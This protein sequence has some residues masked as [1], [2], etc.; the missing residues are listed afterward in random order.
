[1]DRQAAV[2]PQVGDARARARAERIALRRRQIFRAAAR[3][4]V[5]TGYHGMSM[6]AVAD[7]AKMS[8]GLIYQYVSSK[9]ELLQSTI[10]DILEEFRQ[11]VPAAMAK[12]GDDPQ[13]RLVEGFRT[14]CTIIDGMREATLLAYRE[15]Q[16]LPKSGASEVMRL[17]SETMAPL[18]DAVADGIAN[19][20]FRPVSA[21][22]VAHN[23]KMI[24]HGWALKHWDLGARMSL[25]QYIDD[26]LAL[27]FASL[28]AH[29]A[30][31]SDE[32]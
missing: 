3:I 5:R 9:E 32:G 21:D 18:R 2:A 6:Q 22:L 12:V 27:L 11:Q 28:R 20:Q 1:M 31:T 17:E 23:L 26:E 10:L 25:E 14:F 29:P 15:S 7:E 24:A 16:S 19:G 13:M 30:P 8:V 4:M